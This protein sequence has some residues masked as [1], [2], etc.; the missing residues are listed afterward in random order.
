MARHLE[1]DLQENCVRWFRMQHKN[2][3]IFAVPNGGNRNAFEAARL[4]KQGVTAGI[5]DLFIAEP[6]NVLGDYAHGLF[7]ELKI[8]PNKMSKE[9][10]KIQQCLRDRD[11]WCE[12]VYSFDEFV[13]VVNKYLETEK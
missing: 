7:I 13:K 11:Y 10:L 2:V 8:K 3:L 9:Q 12:C 1:D 4:K 5:P 6:R